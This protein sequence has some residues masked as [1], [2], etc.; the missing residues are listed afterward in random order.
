[1]SRIKTSLKKSSNSLFHPTT[2]LCLEIILDQDAAQN[3][4][5]LNSDAGLNK[6]RYKRI[7]ENNKLKECRTRSRNLEKQIFAKLRQKKPKFNIR[8]RKIKRPC[9]Q[10][11]AINKTRDTST[12]AYPSS[13]C[14]C[15]HLH[16]YTNLYFSNFAETKKRTYYKRNDF[17][18]SEHRENIFYRLSPRSTREKEQ[19]ENKKTNNVGEQNEGNKNERRTS[20]H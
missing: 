7:S 8:N 10:V 13:T 9:L 20:N 11:S 4:K 14:I 17:A 16:K 6:M 12:K 2:L 18:T 1:M 3:L 5:W 19:N 15:S